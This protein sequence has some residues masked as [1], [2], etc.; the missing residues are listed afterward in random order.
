MAYSRIIMMG[1]PSH[2]RIESGSNPHT[3]DRWG[4]RKHVDCEK[5]LD[6]WHR[7][8]RTL[9]R[10]GVL[11]YV[12][13]PD[14]EHTGFVFPANAGY[15]PDADHPTPLEERIF[16]RSNLNPSRAGEQSYYEHFVGGLGLRLINIRRPFEGE[17]D[18]IPWNDRTLFTYG[19]IRRP[20]WKFAW[21]IPPWKRR[22]G[23]RSSRLALQELDPWFVEKDVLSIQLVDERYYH[24][25][26]VFVAFG[27]NRRYLLA[28]RPGIA[29]SDQSLLSERKDIIWLSEADAMAYAANSFA[30]EHEG[31][32]TLFMPA[33]VSDEIRGQVEAL[34]VKTILIDVSEFLEKGGGA[35]KCMIGD[36][37]AWAPEAEIDEATAR[38]RNEHQYSPPSD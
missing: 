34:G 14:S 26:T 8:A 27:P 20:A 24:G 11:I 6:Q 4:R 32:H 9:L 12:I 22:Y 10:Y 15:V 29:E 5:A 3:R 18:L 21:Q 16:I 36:L 31:K 28:Y 25:D 1:D 37:G 19:T 2:F 35:I 23:F 33:G 7:M 13:P 17:A 30:L 38:F